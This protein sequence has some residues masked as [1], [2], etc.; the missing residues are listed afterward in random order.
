M[1]KLTFFLLSC[2]IVFSL[3]FLP[4]TG[5]SEEQ[6]SKE[7]SSAGA[8]KGAQ[9]A[10][11]QPAQTQPA[12]PQG[13]GTETGKEPAATGTEKGQAA[14]A[15]KGVVAGK[16]NINTATAEE[17]MT[18]KGIG[19]VLSGRIIDHRQKVG[20]FNSVEELKDVKG[21][22]DKLFLKIKDQLTL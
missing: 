19:K 6:K 8:E 16:V 12:P 22:G 20:K 5:F 2:L 4:Q 18:I 1:K 13:L 21:V 7:G 9:P 15:T 10:T 11:T 14:P 3:S 17:L